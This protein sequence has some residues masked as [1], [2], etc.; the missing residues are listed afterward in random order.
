MARVDIGR[1]D[2]FAPS[3]EAEVSAELVA[4][5]AAALELSARRAAVFVD[6]ARVLA[7]RRAE[8]DAG[9]GF[10]GGEGDEV[11]VAWLDGGGDV[12]SADLSPTDEVLGWDQEAAVGA[13]ATAGAAFQA[14]G[15]F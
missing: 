15:G 2:S 11:E 3:L 8:V 5:W 13:G 10:G 4:L 12:F 1:D 6:R 7:V 14:V 9:A